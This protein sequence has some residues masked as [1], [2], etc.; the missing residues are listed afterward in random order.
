MAVCGRWDGWDKRDGT[1]PHSRYLRRRL[2]TM[3]P[4]NR[5]M[6]SLPISIGIAVF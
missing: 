1:N 4:K 3:T 5:I 2:P 6:V